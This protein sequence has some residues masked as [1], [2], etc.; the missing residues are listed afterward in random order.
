MLVKETSDSV[1]GLPRGHLGSP[2]NRF[3]RLF[4]SPYPRRNYPPLSPRSR[5]MTSSS[6]CLPALV[7]LRT[8]PILFALRPPH[9][10]PVAVVTGRKATHIS[11]FLV[12]FPTICLGRTF[13]T[14]P[15]NRPRF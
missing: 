15:S 12:A 8:K 11:W 9:F 6:S 5:F 14:V 3:V 7:D 1:S 4:A 10:C 13:S 2:V